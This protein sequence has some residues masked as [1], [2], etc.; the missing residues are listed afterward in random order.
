MNK[1]IILLAAAAFLLAG[2]NKF[3]DKKKV[4]EAQ[5]AAA[6]AQAKFAARAAMKTAA[7]RA[8][9]AGEALIGLLCSTPKLME[10]VEGDLDLLDALSGEGGDRAE[11]KQQAA[12]F[13]KRYRP[14]LEKGLASR[15]SSCE[16]LSRYAAGQASAEHKQKFSA[17]VAQKCPRGDKALV[18]KTAE[19]LMHYYASQ[20][21]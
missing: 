12:E 17:L 21:K 6:K 18:E 16:E 7:D 1:S 2:C 13:R 9:K 19:G 11:Q 15:G 8:G 5:E 20:Q 3:A 14:T 4:T 10:A